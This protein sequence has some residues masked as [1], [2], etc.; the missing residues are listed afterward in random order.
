MIALTSIS[1]LTG[2]YFNPV[3]RSTTGLE[4]K[5][6]D[7]G[8][9]ES[10]LLMVAY[11]RGQSK[12]QCAYIT[13]SGTTYS[14]GLSARSKQIC[15]V[16]NSR[17]D[18]LEVSKINF[19]NKVIDVYSRAGSAC[20]VNRIGMQAYK[21]ARTVD[22][23]DFGPGA[24]ICSTEAQYIAAKENV[25]LFTIE[26]I[27]T[28][29]YATFTSAGFDVANTTSGT[30]DQFILHSA[31]SISSGAYQ[32]AVQA[33][34]SVFFTEITAKTKIVISSCSYGTGANSNNQCAT[35]KEEF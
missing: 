21:D 18:A 32:A 24:G 30:E 4:K 7:T 23:T 25:R 19:Y 12:E 28:E 33:L 29:S 13:K 16:P 20:N 9:L 34:D 14:V 27:V 3:Y 6:E 15:F 22:N 2:C 17:A 5:V 1:L 10:L 11:T 35:L 26:N 8:I 31:S